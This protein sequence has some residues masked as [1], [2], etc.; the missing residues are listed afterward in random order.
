MIY[1]GFILHISFPAKAIQA[2]GETF[3]GAVN[4]LSTDKNE[5][6]FQQQCCHPTG[7]NSGTPACLSWAILLKAKNAVGGKIQIVLFELVRPLTTIKP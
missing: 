3:L 2:E 6:T 5:L 1:M 4:D 7:K